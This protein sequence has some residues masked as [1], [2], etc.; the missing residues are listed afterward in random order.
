M[1]WTKADIIKEAYSEIGKSDYEFDL[2]PDI[3]QSGLRRLDSMMASWAGTNGIRIGFSG[4]EGFGEI[5]AQTE[6]P[7]WAFDALYL[8]LALRLAP[9]IGKTVSPETRAAAKQA[10]DL[11]Q[12]RTVIPRPRNLGGGYAGW[13]GS[14]PSDPDPLITGAD[15]FVILEGDAS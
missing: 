5:D 15:G 13:W 10:L 4:G 14:L 12:S 11:L 7:P 8:N 6:V 1:G 2:Q 9:T 3:M